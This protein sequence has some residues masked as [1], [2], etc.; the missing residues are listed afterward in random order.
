MAKLDKLLDGAQA[1]LDPT[2][3][4][5]HAVAGLYATKLFGNDSARRGSLIATDRRLVFYAKKIGGH[6][7]ESFPYEN[8]SS[9]ESGKN[10]LTGG[11]VSFFASGN[12]V[13][14][15]SIKADAME[16]FVAYVRSRMGKPSSTPAANG[17]S[18]ADELKKLA[19][20]RDAGVLSPDEFATQK[21]KL[22]G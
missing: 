6:D 22:L 5:Q 1:H 9:I 19:D 8:I 4:V 10:M 14:M 20:L 15:T 3:E 7:L 12:S 11:H 16:P 2:E 18:L 17:A 13:K 21:A